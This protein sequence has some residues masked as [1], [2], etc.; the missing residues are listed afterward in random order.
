ML[1]LAGEFV[2]V[3]SPL[4]PHSGILFMVY[5]A[6][7]LLDCG[8][9]SRRLTMIEYFPLLSL[10]SPY[11]AVYCLLHPES[12]MQI[13]DTDSKDE[14][15]GFAHDDFPGTRSKRNAKLTALK[16]ESG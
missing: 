4:L 8:G 6:K 1:G 3:F 13:R 12:L 16:E 2:C 14:K 7:R 9:T 15:L 5:Y 11:S 10:S